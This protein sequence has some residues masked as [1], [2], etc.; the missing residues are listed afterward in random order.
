MRSFRFLLS[1]R[2]FLFA[3]VVALSAYA[4][5]LLGD[6]QFG[7]LDGRRTNNDIVRANENATP[8]AA[9]AVMTPGGTVASRD[10]WKQIKVTGTYDTAHTVVWRYLTNDRSESGIDVI[11]PL[12]TPTGVVLV[13]R[14]WVSS[15]DSITLP[16]PAPVVP[17]GTV[18]VVGWLRQDATTADEIDT[19]SGRPSTRALS[20]LAVAKTM[21]SDWKQP[22]LGGFLDL[23]TENG[24][25]AP[26]MTREDLPSLD[27]GP[28]FFYGLQWWFF[29]GLALFGFGYLA[30]EERRTSIDPEFA[31]TMAAR[32]RA[33]LERN[34]KKRAVKAA[35]QAAYDSEKAGRTD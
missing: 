33:Y 25:P 23:R 30:W 27:D 34:Q 35:Y 3:I 10:Q 29:G 5:V 26:G 7:R 14:G 11:V 32:R 13:D 19:S 8:V 24:K 6:W 2:W 21:G 9:N 15:N 28:H 17:R 1:R 16:T 31:E 12:V 18:T 22:V 4:C 20:S